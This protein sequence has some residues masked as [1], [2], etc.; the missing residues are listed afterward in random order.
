MRR[1]L[2]AG[3]FDPGATEAHAHW[4]LGMIL[5]KRGDVAG[6]RAEYEAALRLEP[7]LTDAK[8]ALD[9]MK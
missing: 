3:Q 1:Y 9:R 6:A 8:R 2:E 7:K 5:E 4:R